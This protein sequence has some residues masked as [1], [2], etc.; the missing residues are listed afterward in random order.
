MIIY[1]GCPKIAITFGVNTK[2]H[3]SFSARINVEINV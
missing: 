3:G 2:G 1:K